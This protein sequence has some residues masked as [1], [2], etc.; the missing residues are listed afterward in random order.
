MDVNNCKLGSNMNGKKI[1]AI[2]FNLMK[3]MNFRDDIC[4][5]KWSFPRTYSSCY[6][7]TLMNTKLTKH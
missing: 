2:T 4:Q 6:Y 7:L 1:V 5:Q 3:R